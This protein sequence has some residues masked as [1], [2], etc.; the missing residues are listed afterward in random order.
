MSVINRLRVCILSLVKFCSM[1]YD[2]FILA[3]LPFSGEYK[4]CVYSSSEAQSSLRV[5]RLHSIK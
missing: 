2:Y 1:Y 5:T 3:L 4:L